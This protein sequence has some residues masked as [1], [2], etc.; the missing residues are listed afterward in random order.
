MKKIILDV[1]TGSDDAIAIMTAVLSPELDV[2]GICTVNGNRCVENTTENTL[3]VVEYIGSNVPVYK[4]C[5][6]PMV[7]SLTKGRR[8]CV[9]F[10]GQKNKKE[11][12]HGD[13]LPIPES[14]ITYEKECAV[15]W[16]VKTLMDSDGDIS[17]ID[18]GPLTNLA[19]AMRIQP[20]IIDKIDTLYI[21]GGGWREQNITPAAEF[22]FWIDPEAAKIVINSGCKIVMVPLDATHAGAISIKDAMELR[23]ESSPGA[24]LTAALIEQRLKGYN[25]WQPMQDQTTVPIHDALAVCAAIDMDVLAD[26]RYIHVD[27]DA[28]GGICDGQSVCDVE[29]KDKEAEPNVHIA[30]NAN[31]GRFAELLKTTLKRTV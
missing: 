12:V 30:L 19:M 2:L 15:S 27:V 25:N 14:T 24:K 1:D 17:L 13:Y 16:L 4:G 5:A 29:H 21:M 26:V 8:E 31:V 11:D 9:P 7:V 6:L 23:E 20:G 10:E 28:G 3:R 18:V 22:N